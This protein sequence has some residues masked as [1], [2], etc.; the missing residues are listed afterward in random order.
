MAKK[1]REPKLTPEIQEQLIQ[2]V[3]L[4][5]PYRAACE[6]IGLA[7]SSFYRWKRR[8]K[9]PGK[10]NAPY[11]AFLAALARARASDQARRVKRIEE[12]ARGG[13]VLYEKITTTTKP[14]TATKWRLSSSDFALPE[15]RADAWHLD[16][17]D[18]R[19]WG[20]H[21]QQIRELEQ[22]LKALE[23]ELERLSCMVPCGKPGANQPP[24]ASA[25]ARP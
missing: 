9:E 22:C 14:H 16:R 5:L 21:A 12:A 4:G 6:R 15:W 24:T 20:S 2:G 18:P 1:G 23:K 11:V 3:V 19:T 10:K 25:T 17:T 13:G 8:G 7:L